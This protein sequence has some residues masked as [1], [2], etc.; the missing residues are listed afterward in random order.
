MTNI[1]AA[2]HSMDLLQNQIAPR[3]CVQS[4]R[5]DSGTTQPEPPT[6]YVDRTLTH[7]RIYSS[8]GTGNFHFLVKTISQ[9]F[10][11]LK[12]NEA[13]AGW[14]LLTFMLHLRNRQWLY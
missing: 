8:S 2:I 9:C 1:I 11:S 3:R 13:T 6:N 10:H 4:I 14:R 7:A 5:R 12:S